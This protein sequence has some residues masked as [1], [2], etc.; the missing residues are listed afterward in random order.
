MCISCWITAKSKSIEISSSI[1]Q[2][3]ST[4]SDWESASGNIA[5]E[6]VKTVL[7]LFGE[8]PVAMQSNALHQEQ[9]FVKCKLSSVA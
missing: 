8:S 1:E 7:Q 4:A 9:P 2:C 6:K 3:T 5:Q